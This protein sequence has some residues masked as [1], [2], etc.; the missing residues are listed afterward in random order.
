MLKTKSK[1]GMCNENLRFAF[2]MNYDAVLN[3]EMGEKNN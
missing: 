1:C 3:V 2:A